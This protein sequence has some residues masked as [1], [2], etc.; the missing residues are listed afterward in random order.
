[1]RR[2]VLLAGVLLSCTACGAVHA[3]YPAGGPF[4]IVNSTVDSGAGESTGDTYRVRFT[5]GQP[6]AAYSTGGTF[7]V[8]GGFWG[9]RSNPPTD[10]IFSDAFE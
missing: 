4:A 10:E 5:A 3:Q 6:D 9:S 7:E 8:R 2:R 1:M